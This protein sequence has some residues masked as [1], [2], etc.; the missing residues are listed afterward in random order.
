MEVSEVIRMARSLEKDHGPCGWPAV[1]MREMTTLADG[2]ERLEK[3]NTELKQENEFLKKDRDCDAS[4]LKNLGKEFA[5]VKK[6]NKEL[7]EL[8]EEYRR[9][10]ILEFKR[11]SVPRYNPEK[12]NF[13]MRLDEK[14]KKITGG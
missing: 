12:S 10:L 3:Q 1:R 13:F 8:V 4:T 14:L 6:Q 7:V 2:V 9:Y 11:K 5:K